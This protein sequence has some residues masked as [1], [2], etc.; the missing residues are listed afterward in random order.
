MFNDDEIVLDDYDA[1]Y[2]TRK[3]CDWS[4]DDV[5]GLNSTDQEIYNSILACIDIAKDEG[6]FCFDTDPEMLYRCI[7]QFIINYY[8]DL[9]K[10]VPFELHRY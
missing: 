8:D 2:C 10:D 6:Y 5:L 4:W 3:Q 7:N 1:H 9:G